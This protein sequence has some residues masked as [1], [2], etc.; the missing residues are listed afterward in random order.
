MSNKHNAHTRKHTFIRNHAKCC[1]FPSDGFFF[2]FEQRLIIAWPVDG[3]SCPEEKG[4]EASGQRTGQCSAVGQRKYLRCL[5]EY[6]VILLL[7]SP[8][9][10]P[11]MYIYLLCCIFLLWFRT[12][13]L[14]WLHFWVAPVM[15]F[16][17]KYIYI[18][19]YD[20]KFNAFKAKKVRSQGNDKD[21]FFSFSFLPP[22]LTMET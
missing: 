20:Y 1:I 15:Y 11:H 19:T 7:I 21:F 4:T 22:R 13:F 14:V 17:G 16:I 9:L 3:I 6:F 2:F 5:L 18:N 10:S 8:P 12:Q